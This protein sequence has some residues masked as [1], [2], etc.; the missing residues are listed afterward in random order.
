MV[1]SAGAERRR[2]RGRAGARRPGAPAA[3][4]VLLSLAAVQ[5][6]RAEIRSEYRVLA[7]FRSGDF[8]LAGETRILAVPVTFAVISDRE[9]FR[10][11]VPALSVT[12]DHP[13]TLAGDQVIE[14]N[15]GRGGTESGFGDV[16]V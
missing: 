4:A 9:E 7:S 11:S 3:C 15:G 13:V 1:F 6:A 16:Q 10:L 2:A 8:G 14:R 5:S 12:S